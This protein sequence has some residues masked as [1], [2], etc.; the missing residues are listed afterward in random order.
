MLCSKYFGLITLKQPQG[1]MT[2]DSI[3]QTQPDVPQNTAEN[4]LALMRKQIG[5]ERKA[6]EAAE[7]RASQL[8]QERQKV[9]LPYKEDD[10]DDDSEPYVDHKKT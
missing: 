5:E 3:S 7:A 1:V 9:R 2:V 8:E 4:N 6:R 10:E